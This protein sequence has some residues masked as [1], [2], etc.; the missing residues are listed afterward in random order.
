MDNFEEKFFCA[1]IEKSSGDLLTLLFERYPEGM[2][3]LIISLQFSELLKTSVSRCLP[4]STYLFH[5][6]QNVQTPLTSSA[7]SLSFNLFSEPTTFNNI[8]LTISPNGI[9]DKHKN[10]LMKVSY[11]FM[12]RRLQKSIKKW[13]QKKLKEK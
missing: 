13:Y 5:S 7:D 8:F 6:M 11:L 2:I 9:R 4:A 10:K 12:F 1:V 3:S